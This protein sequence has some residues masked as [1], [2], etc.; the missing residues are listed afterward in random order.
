MI[1]QAGRETILLL[2]LPRT[3]TLRQCW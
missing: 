1:T 2:R 3:C